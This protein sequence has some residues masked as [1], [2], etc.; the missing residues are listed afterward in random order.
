MTLSSTRIKHALDHRFGIN[1]PTLQIERGGACEHDRARSRAASVA[2]NGR[3]ASARRS[4]R[5]DRR[6]RAE[7]AV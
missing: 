6:G 3:R 7:I 5:D 2:L 4:L 1:H